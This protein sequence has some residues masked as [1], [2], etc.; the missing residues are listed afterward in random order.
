MYISAGKC[1]ELRRIWELTSQDHRLVIAYTTDGAECTESP[2]DITIS[3]SNERE[4]TR[5][6]NDRDKCTRTTLDQV[7]QPILD[8]VVSAQ[9]TMSV[10]WS[11]LN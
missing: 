8:Q 9:A 2:N 1:S 4:A 5:E 3:I 7:T 6:T 10:I 11:L